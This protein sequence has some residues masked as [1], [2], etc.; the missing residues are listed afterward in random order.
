MTAADLIALFES[1][2]KTYVETNATDLIGPLFENAA[3]GVGIKYRAEIDGRRLDLLLTTPAGRQV[4]FTSERPES[5]AADSLAADLRML[6]A[7][8]VE[9]V[10]RIRGNDFWDR[11]RDLIW[12][13]AAREP[14]LFDRRSLRLLRARV[15]PEAIALGDDFRAF[16]IIETRTV[17]PGYPIEDDPTPFRSLSLAAGIP[18]AVA[19]WHLSADSLTL[20]LLAFRDR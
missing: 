7:T 19:G 5:D 15:S 9:A 10:F 12:L 6:D 20:P 4:V 18:T 11:E 17:S 8:E 13:L 14:D 16:R 1:V 2:P 3:P